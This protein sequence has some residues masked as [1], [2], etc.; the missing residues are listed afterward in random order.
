[1]ERAFASPHVAT[2]T[3]HIQVNESAFSLS[4][5]GRTRSVRYVERAVETE[6]DFRNLAGE[7]N[8]A[9]KNR[10]LPAQMPA[11]VGLVTAIEDQD[12]EALHSSSWMSNVNCAWTALQ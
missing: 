12:G 10:R 7:T 8:R 4:D 9:L 6:Y 1:M 11:T 2:N 3:D 5:T